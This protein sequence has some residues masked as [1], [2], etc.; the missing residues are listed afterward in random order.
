MKNAKKKVEIPNVLTNPAYKEAHD[1]LRF[2]EQKLKEYTT[3]LAELRAARLKRWGAPNEDQRADAVGKAM[4]IL[5]GVVEVDDDSKKCTKFAQD[6]H[7]L[8]QAIAAQQI[9]V[10]EAA[11]KAGA[12]IAQEMKPAHQEIVR[13]VMNAYQVLYETNQEERALRGAMEDAGYSGT[14]LLPMFMR[15]V[16]NSDDW[17]G[18]IAYYWF[19]EAQAYVFTPE[20]LEAEQARL[21]DKQRAAFR[22]HAPLPAR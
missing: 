1:K 16:D 5:S 2:L 22:A 8:E 11:T 7:V 15:G 10:R 19:R 9:I 13:R 18:G 14:A 20:E 6:I 17:R 12:L 4:Q 3:E 21:A